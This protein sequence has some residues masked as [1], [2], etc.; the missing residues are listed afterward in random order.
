MSRGSG[1]VHELREQGLR[2]LLGAVVAS[3]AWPLVR[4]LVDPFSV[5]AA[6]VVAGLGGYAVARLAILR[7]GEAEIGA[8]RE[9][10]IWAAAFG[11]LIA[12]VV[13]HTAAR[14]M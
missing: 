1:V 8:T 13:L 5:V 10:G 6:V 4:Q 12:G 9:D 11:G 3:G 2:I 7:T 14:V